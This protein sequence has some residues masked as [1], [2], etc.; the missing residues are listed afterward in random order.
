MTRFKFFYSIL[1]NSL[2]LC[3]L[4]ET[5][6]LGSAALPVVQVP[7]DSVSER[8]ILYN[9][10]LWRNL[11]YQVK[12]DQFL[13]SNVFLPGTVSMNGRTFKNVEIRYDILND[14]LTIPA[15]R[16]SALQINKEM[17]DSFSMSFQGRQYRFDKFADDSLK[18]VKGYLQILYK[19]KCALYIKY[20]KE[21]E[22]LAVDK[23]YDKF[24]QLEKIWFVRD[25]EVFPVSGK[26][27]LMKVM[28]DQKIAV[29][30]Y[31][32]KNKLKM[33]KSAPESFV[34]LVR[35]YDSLLY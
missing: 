3:L 13:F 25:G 9:G 14:E 24:Y 27:D 8:Q 19:G 17:V 2:V 23:K 16:I 34:P 35:Y 31:V 32:K 4:T 33:S 20:R 22:L 30:D 10:R 26:G 29:K 11:Y 1:F 21:I 5:T 12:G 15:T 7:Q 18:G 6:T 28:D